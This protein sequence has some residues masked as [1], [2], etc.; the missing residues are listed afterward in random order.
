MFAHAKVYRLALMPVAGAAALLAFEPFGLYPLAWIALVPL[1]GGRDGPRWHRRLAGGYLYGLG[2]YGAGLVWLPASIGSFMAVPTGLAAAGYVVIVGFLALFPAIFRCLIGYMTSYRWRVLVLAPSLWVVLEAVR[3]SAFGGLPWLGLAASQAN[4]P[5]GAWYPLVG[6]AGVTAL[7]VLLN[8]AGILLLSAFPRPGSEAGEAPEAA[9]PAEAPTVSGDGRIGAGVVVAAALATLVLV[10]LDWVEAQGEP[11]RVALIQA[12]V[13]GR[14]EL[15][16]GGRAD[17][18]RR[19]RALVAEVIA[20]TDV[21]VLPEAAMDPASD[22]W[23]ALVDAV[24]A[25]GA[26]LV[27]GVLEDTPGGARYNS[28]RLFAGSS[29]SVYRKQR[30]VPIA[31]ERWDRLRHVAADGRPPMLPGQTGATLPFDGTRLGLS[32]CWEIH[33]G[34]V[35][36]ESAREGAGLLV[37]IA[38]ESWIESPTEH[39][40]SLAVARM[41]AAESGRAL[42]RVVNR[43][44][45]AVIDADGR[46]VETRDGPC[47]LRRRRAS[48]FIPG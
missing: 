24:T 31:E 13:P 42:V 19:Y 17:I 6:E 46:V 28:A 44:L 43:G 38:N 27:V 32:I 12:A 21:A 2:F 25:V 11:V 35:T 23:A 16:P 26:V 8:G 18:A 15:P 4:G 9:R 45:S 34:H 40:R 47:R 48:P 3:F 30:L 36:R 33:F 20:E 7:V 29:T 37:N 22:D 1:I 39:A 5:L 10:P 41:R 14:L